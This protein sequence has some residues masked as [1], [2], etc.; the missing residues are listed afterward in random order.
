M[1]E[2]HHCRTFRAE[3]FHVCVA[4]VW[5]KSVMLKSADNLINEFLI[6][7]Q[8]WGGGGDNMVQEGN[9]NSTVRSAMS[10]YLNLGTDLSAG[11][12]ITLKDGET[13]LDS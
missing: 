2:I 1:C 12:I 3:F 9:R 13:V 4:Q 6:V 8:G 11:A 10:S 5:Y 7:P